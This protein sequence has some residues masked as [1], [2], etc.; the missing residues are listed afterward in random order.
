MLLPALYLPTLGAPFDFNDDGG[1]V[2]PAPPQPLASRLRLVWQKIVANYEHL[3]P[4]RPTLWLHWEAQAELF[5]GNRLPWRLARL[6]WS[7]LAAGML[8]WLMAEL[9]IHPAAAIFAAAVALWNPFRGEIWRSLTLSEGVAMPYA[10]FALICAVRAARTPRPLPWDLAGVASVLVAL[11]CKNTF[12]AIVPAQMLLRIAP[13]GSGW[14][15]GWRRHGRRALWIAATL[16]LPIAHFLYFRRHWHPGQYEVAAP[17][18]AQ[19]GRILKALRGATS[20]DFL[21]A[22]PA[23]SAVAVIAARR[24]RTRPEAP[25]H[26]PW[27]PYRAA[28]MAGAALLLAGTGIYLPFRGMAG[29]YTIPAVWGLD[30]GLAVLC[31]ALFS[32]PSTIWKRA[33]SVALSIGL[34]GVAVQ[35]VG[36]QA[37]AAAGANVLWRALE[38]IEQEAPAGAGVGWMVGSPPPFRK[39]TPSQTGGSPETGV[40]FGWHLHARTRRDLRYVVIDDLGRPQWRPELAGPWPE[41][42]SI[43]VTAG[44]VA[45]RLLRP[46]AG[47]WRRV[48]FRVTYRGGRW[49]ECYVWMRQ[50]VGG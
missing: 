31:S 23:L 48:P 32:A 3:G 26:S 30:L 36:R 21:G 45:P 7:G 20:L 8:L 33:A 50:P 38:F 44:P 43:V 14:R 27:R 9:K 18:M 40:H 49:R 17:T 28:L 12:A 41:R 19:L 4:F 22:G 25:S 47:H 46:S 2:Y 15:D 16:L 24:S 29:R 11:G 13:D 1:H 10:L 5:N 42:L 6:V 37:T 34:V 39:V 35:A